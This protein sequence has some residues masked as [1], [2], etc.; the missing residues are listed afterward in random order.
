M[1]TAATSKTGKII[2]SITTLG[3]TG[4]LIMATLLKDVTASQ[5]KEDSPT[6]PRYRIYELHEKIKKETPQ[7]IIDEFYPKGLEGQTIRIKLIKLKTARLL[8]FDEIEGHYNRMISLNNKY[9]KTYAPAI[10]LLWE[11][12]QKIAEGEKEGEK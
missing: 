4:T 8:H 9:H 5:L 3:V 6:F 10:I 12:I 1:R 2:Q 11:M 7:E